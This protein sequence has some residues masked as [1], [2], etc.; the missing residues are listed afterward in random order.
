M[1]L[2]FFVLNMILYKK[3]QRKYWMRVSDFMKKIMKVLLLMG[4]GERNYLKNGIYLGMILESLL[5]F[6]PKCSHIKKLANIQGSMLLLRN[7]I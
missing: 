2:M 7:T 5:I 4:K 6:Y 3:L 1:L